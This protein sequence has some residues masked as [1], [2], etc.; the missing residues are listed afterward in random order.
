[1]AKNQDLSP[2]VRRLV[3]QFA[4][5][6]SLPFNVAVECLISSG[7][8]YE[9]TMRPKLFYPLNPVEKPVE[10]TVTKL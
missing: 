8:I 2:E 9:N 1:M 7:A 6:E 4:A 10:N 3:I 5:A